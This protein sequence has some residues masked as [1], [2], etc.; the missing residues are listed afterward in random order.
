MLLIYTEYKTSKNKKDDFNRYKAE[1]LRKEG[2]K[3][4]LVE[5]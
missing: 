5:E 1:F 4:E 2:F 3:V